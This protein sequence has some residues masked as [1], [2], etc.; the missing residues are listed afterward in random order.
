V[1]VLADRLFPRPRA[2]FAWSIAA[3]VTLFCL[4]ATWPKL[5]PWQ[6]SARALPLTTLCVAAILWIPRLRR[7][8]SLAGRD[9]WLPLALWSVYSLALLGKVILKVKVGH[10][11]FV[12]AMPAVLLLVAALVSLVPRSLQR[13]WNGGRI[14]R[15]LAFAVVCAGVVFFWNLSNRFYAQK[16][17]TLGSGGD[18]ITV[19]GRPSGSR[20][21]VL[22][23]TLERLEREMGPRD[24]L[25]VLPEGVI[26]NYWLRRV[27]PTP[28]NL[29]LPTEV[30][31]FGGDEAV[32]REIRSAPPDFIVLAHRM[33][34]EFGVGPFGRDP[35]NGRLLL[36]WVRNHYHPVARIGNQPFVGKGFGC[37]ILR[38][39]AG[40]PDAG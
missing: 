15:A 19:R 14:A 1:C 3:G 8:V 39:K 24:T 20:G 38:R 31:A 22:A 2:S 27:N 11:G 25:L 36:A 9:R 28:F 35:R 40:L 16:D 29:F 10:Y 13:R 18:A 34:A 30:D 17:F 32:L 37:V 4:L 5:V 7:H 12:L 23:R 6:A 21:A 33:S 26:L